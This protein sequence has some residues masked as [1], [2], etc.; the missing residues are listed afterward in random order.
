[1]VGGRSRY[2]VRVRNI[3]NRGTSRSHM[4]KPQR[5][6]HVYVRRPRRSRVGLWKAADDL[7]PC[8]T[9]LNNPNMPKE[10]CK[11]CDGT[12]LENIARRASLNDRI[13]Q[14]RKDTHD[15]ATQHR[16]DS[17]QA[18]DW[19]TPFIDHPA[20]SRVID[21]DPEGNPIEANRELEDVGHDC[22]HCEGGKIM[23]LSDG[24][25]GC[26]TEDCFANTEE[27]MADS[28]RQP[29]I[30]RRETVTQADPQWTH[31]RERGGSSGGIAGLFPMEQSEPE[32]HHI[33]INALPPQP[34]Q[35]LYDAQGNPIM[36]PHDDI[37]AGEPMDIAMQLLKEALDTPKSGF[38]D[39]EDYPHR[40][41][42]SPHS[43]AGSHV[44]VHNVTG[45]AQPAQRA[46][47][48]YESLPY[49]TLTGWGTEGERKLWPMKAPLTTRRSSRGKKGK[50]RGRTF[51]VSRD[52]LRAHAIN[53]HLKEQMGM[54]GIE[55]PRDFSTEDL[56][57]I[58]LDYRMREKADEKIGE[59]PLFQRLPVNR[60]FDADNYQSIN[61][62]TDMFNPQLGRQV[63]RNWQDR[64]A[65]IGRK[66][67][68]EPTEEEDAE[69][70][71]LPT[72]EMKP[73]TESLD[74][75]GLID[76]EDKGDPDWWRGINRSSVMGGD[77]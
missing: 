21:Y 58:L 66:E 50:S 12:G 61:E 6:S 23:W 10:Q 17:H 35:M 54:R 69:W 1:M 34:V 11:V 26:T 22:P 41:Q 7:A 19:K 25:Q 75:E 18:P 43:K 47:Q 72:G 71:L 15:K 74:V 24:A 45:I 48:F 63:R 57:Q 77:A 60:G 31:Q 38:T 5:T 64:D 49:G 32:D 42:K 53:E 44:H 28:K 65:R 52:K 51:G 46:R 70:G 20:L 2:N 36:P 37:K 29:P 67:S 76:V 62:T 56:N 3:A 13:A 73:W 33:E 16:R 4:R 68:A 14:A 59:M 27:G 8:R 55:S 40:A 30:D 39:T 9:C